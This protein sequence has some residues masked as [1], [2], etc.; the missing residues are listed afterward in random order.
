ML[1]QTLSVD[2]TSLYR[3]NFFDVFVFERIEE[4]K[5]SPDFLCYKEAVDN[6]IWDKDCS[7][8]HSITNKTTQT[9]HRTHPK[10]LTV[11]ILYKCSCL[12]LAKSAFTLMIQ[13]RTDFK[14]PVNIK[15]IVIIGKYLVQN[16]KEG[17]VCLVVLFACGMAFYLCF[18]VK[19][20]SK[21]IQKYKQIL[22]ENRMQDIQRMQTTENENYEQ[23][24][25]HTD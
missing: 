22:H 5:D 18:K 16:F 19:Q 14:N 10:E 13:T 2:I 9:I 15:S 25:L 21:R 20:S 8:L 23:V 7:F 11:I 4:G 6:Q 24:D 3:N 12:F 17:M 1:K